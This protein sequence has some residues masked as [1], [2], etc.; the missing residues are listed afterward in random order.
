MLQ[1]CEIRKQG[2]VTLFMFICS[3]YGSIIYPQSA[4]TAVLEFDG[5]KTTLQKGC[6]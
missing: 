3:N 4:L 6:E 2:E 1:G 5:P